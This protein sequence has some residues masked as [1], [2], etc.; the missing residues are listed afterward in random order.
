MPPS[1]RLTFDDGP[2][3]STPSLL[4]VLKRASY[5]ATFFVLGKHLPA[6]QDLAVRML[7][8]GH[9]LGNHTWT[10]ARPGDLSADELIEEVEATD[11]LIRAAHQ[12]AGLGAPR[13][14]P[15]RLPYGLQ[16]DDPRQIVLDRLARPH[17]GWTLIV[18][19]WRTPAPASQALA[20]AMLSHFAAQTS[21]GQDAVI[22][23]HDSSRH[24]DLR[25]ATVDAVRL[26]QGHADWRSDR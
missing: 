23:L 10:H 8:E 7:H 11:A 3:P 6:A 1:L 19:D 12:Q 9:T 21:A 14:I 2:G 25:P 22:C 24:H 26:L 20:D 16:A 13:A 18:D 4:D 15:L 5:K 17:V